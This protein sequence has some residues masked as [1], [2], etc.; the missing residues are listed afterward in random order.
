MKAIFISDT[1]LRKAADE[2]YVHLLNFFNDIKSGQLKALIDKGG[3]EVQVTAVTDIY[4]VGDLFDFWFCNK[5]K[6]YPEFILIINKLIELQKSGI[7][8]HL[9]EGNHDFFL[10]EY[11]HDVLGMEVFEEWA[12]VKINGLRALIAHGDTTDQTN[13]KYLLFR[14]IIRSRPFYHFQRFIPASVRWSLASL[15][16][17]ASKQMTVEDGDVLVEKM[18]SFAVEK[19]QEDYDAIIL[20]HCHLPVMRHYTVAGKKKSF[21][22]LGDWINHYSFAYC[23]NKNF[24]LGYY[25][26]R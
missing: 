5:D 20:G 19:L 12:D 17:M 2:R 22:A 9:S 15:S 16:S 24:Y 8:I 3:S 7:H 4:I 14:R 1:H 13:F 18:L 21:V 10:Q 11:F 6:I 26:T 25:R 23:E